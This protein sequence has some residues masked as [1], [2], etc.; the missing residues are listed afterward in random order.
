MPLRM[1]IDG[2]KLKFEVG[3]GKPSLM[4]RLEFWLKKCPL[5]GWRYKAPKITF[6]KCG[7]C[8]CCCWKLHKPADSTHSDWKKGTR[9]VIFN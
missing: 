7:L 5:C 8:F 4:N 1:E 3:A 2:D 6:N 9:V